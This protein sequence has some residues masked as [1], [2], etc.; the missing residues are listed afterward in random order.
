MITHSRRRTFLSS[1]IATG[2]GLTILPS[3]TL[4]G[5]G[6]GEKL[7]IALIGAYGRGKQ[8]YHDLRTQNIVAICDVHSECMKFAA[9]EFPKAKQ[10]TDW[11]KCLEQKDLEAVVICTPD[12]HH[13]F[14]SI[15][16]MNRGLHVY[17]EKPLGDCVAEARAVREVYLKN[18]KKLA[19]QHG[20][21]RHANPNFD[22]VAEMIKGGA[23]GE[24]KD[25]HT[26]GNRTHNKTAY[27]PADGKPPAGINWNQWIGPV[28]WHPYNPGYFDLRPGRGC[29]SWNMYDDFGS[30]Q[31]GDMG[32]HTV[33]LAWNAIDAESPIKAKAFGDSPSPYVCPSKLTAI[34]TLPAN[35]W[36]DEIRLAWYQGG[37]RPKSP[38][39]ALDLNKISHGA[40]FKGT[41]GVLIADFNNRILLPLGKDTDMTYYTPPHKARAP[42]GGFMQQWFNACKG[43]L[44]TDCNFDYAGKMI[45]TLM[46]GLA[47]HKAGKELKYDAKSGRVT[48]DEKANEY[49]SKKYREGWVLNG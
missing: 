6:P 18:K 36:R 40:L 38:N 43:D 48:N 41:K 10:Y 29:L 17:C 11:R 47:A 5:K 46:L 2:A 49:L 45:E 7:N 14:I 22:R 25:V 4:A 21:Q 44:K 24:L 39:N 3:G 42:I 32:S 35:N 31:V 23:I 9:K 34:F 16:A 19:T 33:D 12:H 27:L 30:W 15:W 13:A 28:Q 1:S 8:H 26:W 37:P 20:T